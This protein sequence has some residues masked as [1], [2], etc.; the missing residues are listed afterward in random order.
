MPVP[1]RILIVDVENIFVISP[2]VKKYHPY[3]KTFLR[4]TQADRQ[5][6][7]RKKSKGQAKKRSMANHRMGGD[8]ITLRLKPSH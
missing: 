5:L 4:E 8:I 2:F 7:L 1:H 6:K 3:L